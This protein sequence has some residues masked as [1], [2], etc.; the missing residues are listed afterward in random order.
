MSG[1]ATDYISAVNEMYGKAKDAATS[2]ATAVGIPSPLIRYFGRD[3]DS[4]PWPASKFGVEVSQVGATN[5]Q[6]AF[7]IGKRR[8]TTTGTLY[9]RVQAPQAGSNGF[10]LGRKWCDGMKKAF[11]TASPGAKV[12]YRNARVSELSPERGAYRFN[13]EIDYV[14]DELQ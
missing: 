10:E 4:T 8:Y 11:R 9:L 12:W 5:R 1:I 2:V 6:T 14:Y 7:G 13:V 3:Q